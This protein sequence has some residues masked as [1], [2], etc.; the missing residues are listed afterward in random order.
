M[1]PSLDWVF[2]KGKGN[3]S[4]Y[5]WVLGYR[6]CISKSDIQFR[7]SVPTLLIGGWGV[8]LGPYG[9]DRTR[10][11]GPLSGQSES[12]SGHSPVLG[13]RFYSSLTHCGTLGPSTNT[14]RVS[15][16][17]THTWFHET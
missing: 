6:S 3:L 16:M 11:R 15:T 2:P 13:A 14:G 12:C 1:S 17:G 8:Q 9:V 5:T 10:D 7:L 4:C